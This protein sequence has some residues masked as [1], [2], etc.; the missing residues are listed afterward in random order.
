MT[1]TFM[2]AVELYK[3]LIRSKPWF[4]HLGSEPLPGS[5]GQSD[6][7]PEEVRIDEVSEG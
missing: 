4:N 3:M 2:V 6:L 5:T 1:I 7:T